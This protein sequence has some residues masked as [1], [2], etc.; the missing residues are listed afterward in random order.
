MDYLKMKNS[1]K[2]FKNTNCKFFPCHKLK[3]TTFFNCLF[4]YCPLY[5]DPDCGGN[6]IMKGNIKD[7]SNCI[8]PHTKKGYDYIQR[9]LKIYKINQ[10]NVK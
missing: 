3:D 1:Y 2:Y 4:C 6:Y 10:F 8:L 5:S 7:C 9:K